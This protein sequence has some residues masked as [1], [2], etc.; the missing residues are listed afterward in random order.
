MAWPCFLIERHEPRVEYITFCVHKHR[1]PIHVVPNA[2]F[3]ATP[4]DPPGGWPEKCTECGVATS[5]DKDRDGS[6]RT[7]MGT[8]DWRNPA[9]GEIKK[10]AYEFG[11]G[12]MFV[13]P[14]DG[15]YWGGV[16]VILPPARGMV[17]EWHVDGRAVSGGRWTRT[18]TPPRITVSPSILTD[19]YHGFL[20]NGVLTDSLPDRPMP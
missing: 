4:F 7:K 3:E 17:D 8:W 12:A 19:A 13:W 15:D 11:A 16:H 2:E 1:V 10:H 6:W 20:Q 9:T 14:D 5:Y 18:G